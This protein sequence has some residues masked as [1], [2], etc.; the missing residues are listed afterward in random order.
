MRKP[1]DLIYWL[2]DRPPT[3][4]IL[5]AGL[6]QAA[7]VLVFL[8]PA[9]LLARATDAPPGQAAA[10]ISLTLIASAIG[11]MLQA[12]GRAGIGCGLLAPIVPATAFVAPTM[13]AA[14]LGGLPLIAGMTLGAGLTALVLARLLHRM[15][16]LIPAEIAGTVV[17]IIGLSVALA[18][19]RMLFRTPDAGP[20]AMTDAAVAAITLAVAVGLSVWAVG[21]L[22]YVC[23]LIAM[24]CGTFAAVLLDAADSIASLDV[25]ELPVVG[26]PV[27]DHIGYAFDPALLPVF[28]VASLA[29]ALK[30]VGVIATLQKINDADWV[31]PDQRA[32]TAGVACDGVTMLLAGLLGTPAQNT[33][34]THAVIQQATGVTSRV[35]AFATAATCLLLALFPRFAAM[36]AMVPAPIIAATLFYAGGLMLVNGMQLAASRLLD[37]R[38]SLVVGLGVTSALVVETLPQVASWLPPDLRPLLTATAFGTVVVLALNTIL[39]IGIRRQASLTLPPV[40]AVGERLWDFVMSAGARWGARKDVFTA[41]ASAIAWCSEAIAAAGLAKGDMTITIGFD[42]HRIDVRVT[43]AGPPVQISATA[44]TA[45]DMLDDE[46]ASARLASHMLRRLAERLKIQSRA[47]TTEIHMAF[48]H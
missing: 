5:S 14:E 15:R 26:L 19:A 40:E 12:I 10:I 35:I 47:G 8:F 48:E 30:T 7:V 27:L 25:A 45:L 18:G 32:T 1:A 2:N 6:Q 23:V 29:S 24:G 11:T 4:V 17:F 9:I 20:P 41:A 42:E 37:T 36:L 3:A 33:S 34:T 44:P 28:L 39:R 16:A 46:T 43:Y 13:L 21:M 22:R 38:K 31:R